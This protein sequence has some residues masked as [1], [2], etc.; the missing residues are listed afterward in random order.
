VSFAGNSREV[1]D[2]RGAVPLIFSFRV[3]RYKNQSH[4][5]QYNVHDQVVASPG[6]RIP[7]GNPQLSND[8][9]LSAVVV[10]NLSVC[11]LL[12]SVAAF[13]LRLSAD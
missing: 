13:I 7:D 8:E 12:V 1:R 3:Q 2:D 5:M 4:Q 9:T 10:V 11:E 6:R